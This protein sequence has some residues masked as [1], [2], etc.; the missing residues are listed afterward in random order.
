[1]TCLSNRRCHSTLAADQRMPSVYGPVSCSLGRVAELLVGA[2]FPL[3]CKVAWH[4][5]L[6]LL[7]FAGLP[8]ITSCSSRLGGQELHRR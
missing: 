5:Q 2:V 6:G 7:T 8:L 4:I 1:M 3:F